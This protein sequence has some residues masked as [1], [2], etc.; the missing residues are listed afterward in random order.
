MTLTFIFLLSSTGDAYSIM[1][2]VQVVF[3]CSLENHLCN[4]YETLKGPSLAEV[5]TVDVGNSDHVFFQLLALPVAIF[6][7]VLLFL[8]LKVLVDCLFI[9]T[10]KC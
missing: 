10:F 9:F 3:S 4:C 8:V 1:Q 7:L 5:H 2:F 6:S